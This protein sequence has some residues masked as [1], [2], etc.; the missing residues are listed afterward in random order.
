V[1]T[2]GAGGGSI[3]RV[4]PGGLLAVG[5]ESAGADPGPI[6]YGRGG[7]EPT[8]SDA[9]LLLGRLDP[10]GLL[11]VE[12]PVDPAEIAAIFDAKIGAPLGLST[13]GAAEAVLRVANTLMA[14]AIRMVSISLG[15]DPRDFALF[16]FGGAG[17]LHATALA[18]EMGVPRVLVP[19]RPG[20]TNALGCMV[21]DLRHDFVRTVTVPVDEANPER[22][23][24]ILDEMIAEGRRLIDAEPV[25]VERTDIWVSADMQ[26]IGQTHV[27]RVP[28][29]DARPDRET[30]RDLFDR[31]YHARF[32][33]DLPEV[34]AQVVN[35]NVSAI[36]RRPPLDL[37]VLI[38]PGARAPSLAAAQI[39]A[40]P[41]QFGQWYDTPVY[42]RERLPHDARID[43]PA[44]VQQMDTTIVLEPCCTA[45]QDRLGN[46]IVDVGPA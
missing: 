10:E 37:A 38:D 36:G 23:Q 3:A 34:R 44:I 2:V 27:L 20:I 18:R 22:L 39:A 9:N 33:V 16:A 21:A 43:G 12:T 32:H 35:L 45:R 6:C 4:A 19:A 7:T 30:L 8:I 1:R 46:L 17:P 24:A 5:P 31:A 41:V 28:L 14:G 15:H 40:R 26:F 29:P 11:S 25:P 13:E 42:D